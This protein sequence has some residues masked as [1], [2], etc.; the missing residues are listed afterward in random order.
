V[1]LKSRLQTEKFSIPQEEVI[2]RVPVFLAAFHEQL[3][4]QAVKRLQA[5]TIWANDY[6]HFQAALAEEPGRFVMAHWDGTT[7]TEQRIKEET[8]ATIRVIPHRDSLAEYWSAD[9][10]AHSFTPGVCIKTQKPSAQRV[11]FAKAY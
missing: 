7:E 6:A 2:E 5:Q 4:A 8:K 1:V 9:E 11:L 10:V 3:W